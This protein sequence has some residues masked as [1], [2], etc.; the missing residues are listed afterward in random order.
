MGLIQGQAKSISKRLLINEFESSAIAFGDSSSP[1]SSAKVFTTAEDIAK[2]DLLAIKNNL[3]YKY[4]G[5]STSGLLLVGVAGNSAA[6]GEQ[7]TLVT[8]DVQKSGLTGTLYARKSGISTSP[9]TAK[10]ADED[11]CQRIGTGDGTQVYIQIEDPVIL[12]D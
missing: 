5:L 11:I 9:L 2:D 3:A 1:G 4:T 7:V 8:G 6:S 12:D 10:T